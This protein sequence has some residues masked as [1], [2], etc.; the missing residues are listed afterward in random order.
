MVLQGHVTYFSTCITKPMATKLGKVVTYLKIFNP[1]IH[2]TISTR[3]HVRSRDRLKKIYLHYHNTYGYQTWE[4][5]YIQEGVSFD[6]VTPFL[7]HGLVSDFDFSDTICW[8]K[9]QTPKSSTTS[10][11]FVYSIFMEYRGIRSKK[12]FY[13][14]SKS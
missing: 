2:T 12:I 14:L 11:S 8:F 3:G 4:D 1:L 13:R 6:K 10:T 7:S 5:G 9:A